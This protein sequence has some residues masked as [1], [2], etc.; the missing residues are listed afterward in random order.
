MLFLILHF[1]FCI[2]HFASYIFIL[3]FFISFCTGYITGFHYL[4]FILFKK[5]YAF[6]LI[7]LILIY[8]NYVRVAR[9][10]IL[11][12]TTTTTTTKHGWGMDS[13]DASWE[14]AKTW[15]RKVGARNS[16]ADYLRSFEISLV[17]FSK[18]VSV[19]LWVHFHF[20]TVVIHPISH[21]PH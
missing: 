12:Y 21:I 18:S 13:R 11:Q 9:V 10:I 15:K 14:R 16:L 20:E 1:T 6:I 17:L 8:L 4:L 2:L 19:L 3:H 7:R 5:F